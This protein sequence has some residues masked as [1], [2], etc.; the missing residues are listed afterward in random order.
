MSSSTSQPQRP[1]LR[2]LRSS[3]A[4]QAFSG[5]RTKQTL[6]PSSNITRRTKTQVDA[7]ASTKTYKTNGSETSQDK[8][9]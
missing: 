2:Q 4:A 1:G 7:P 5:I 8:K 3:S 6:A 9:G